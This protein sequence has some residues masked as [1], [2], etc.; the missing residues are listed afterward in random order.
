MQTITY[1]SLASLSLASDPRAVIAFASLSQGRLDGARSVA[2]RGGQGGRGT[3]GVKLGL[4]GVR[5]AAAVL[6]ASVVCALAPLAHAGGQSSVRYVCSTQYVLGGTITTC[7]P[8]A[9]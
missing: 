6:V 4:R 8:V 3:T 7:T 1:T 9:R 2:S 5:Y